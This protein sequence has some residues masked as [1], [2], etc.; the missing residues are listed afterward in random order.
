MRI[1]K[2]ALPAGGRTVWWGEPETRSE[3]VVGIH[4]RND[5][6]LG[7]REDGMEGKAELRADWM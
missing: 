5:N 6:G 4:M 7:R 2:P 1:R 3:V